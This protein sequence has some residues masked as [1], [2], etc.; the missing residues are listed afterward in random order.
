MRLHVKP[1]TAAPS[2]CDTR[3]HLSQHQGSLRAPL[4]LAGFTR[5]QLEDSAHRQHLRRAGDLCCFRRQAVTG[6]C[7]E[8]RTSGRSGKR[9][10]ADTRHPELH[11]VRTL[12]TGRRAS[13]T[14][15][16]L[17]KG[18]R[19]TAAH[20]SVWTQSRVDAATEARDSHAA[21]A[22]AWPRVHAGR[23]RGARVDAALDPR[24][25]TSARACLRA[26][27]CM[28]T[29]THLCVRALHTLHTP[30]LP[31]E[32]WRAAGRCTRH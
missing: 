6:P 8:S 24:A 10:V 22:R 3:V 21:R 1:R 30:S 25:C 9:T 4:L 27:A 26:A 14:G 32:Q 31:L 28:L 13:S 19:A 11:A 12:K 17:V 5:R 18:A 7:S 20:A 16:P 29:R 15:S 23:H 2:D